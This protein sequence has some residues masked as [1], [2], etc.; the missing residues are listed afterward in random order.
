M[1]M[2]CRVNFGG[3]GFKV[4][5]KYLHCLNYDIPLD[6]EYLDEDTKKICILQDRLQEIKEEYMS[7]DARRTGCVLD[8]ASTILH[9][10]EM[11]NY[12][13]CSFK[14]SYIA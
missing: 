4:G 10:D 6:T 14:K 1:K 8:V 9:Q 11:Q 12:G 5:R 3:Q 7:T 2:V 13:L